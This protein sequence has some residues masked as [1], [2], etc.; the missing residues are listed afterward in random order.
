M[1]HQVIFGQ[2]SDKSCESGKDWNRVRIAVAINPH[3]MKITLK[4]S[5]TCNAHFTFGGTSAGVVSIEVVL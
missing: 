5:L 4:I 3:E 2:F 1:E